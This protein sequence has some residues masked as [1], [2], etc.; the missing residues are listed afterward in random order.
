MAKN[1]V[2]IY[3]LEEYFLK[4]GGNVFTARTFDQLFLP[5]LT[6]PRRSS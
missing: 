3:C 4:K 5:M 2:F 6:S 1:K